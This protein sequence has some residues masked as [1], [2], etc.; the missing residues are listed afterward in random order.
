MIAPLLAPGSDLVRHSLALGLR[1]VDAATD[2]P[3]SA[4]LTAVLETV[5]ARVANLTLGQKSDGAALRFDTRIGRLFAGPAHGVAQATVLIAPQGGLGRAMPP[6]RSVIPRRLVIPVLLDD[7]GAP[8]A[9]GQAPE[10]KW[11]FRVRMHCGP[12]FP[13]AAGATAIRGRLAWTDPTD[14][15][16]AP[17]R[18]GHVVAKLG[19]EVVATARTD[20]RGEYV[21]KIRG[22]PAQTPNALK[23]ITVALTFHTPAHAPAAPP[24]TPYADVATE[25]LAL[26]D[27]AADAPLPGATARAGPNATVTPGEVITLPTFLVPP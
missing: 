22:R 14:P 1:Y 6:D 21:L 5:G 3:L 23:P 12:T 4:P 11:L 18:W 13:L 9:T 7:E 27:L 17:L 2:A 25:A 16:G 20:D 26:P 15:E 19:A 10:G 24:M 8:R